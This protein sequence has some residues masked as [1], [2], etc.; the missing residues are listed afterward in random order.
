MNSHARRLGSSFSFGVLSPVRI[1]VLGDSFKCEDW[2][3]K[4]WAPCLV[5]KNSIP[6]ELRSDLSRVSQTRVL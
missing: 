4:K 5:K 6:Y 2:W 1:I 3:D